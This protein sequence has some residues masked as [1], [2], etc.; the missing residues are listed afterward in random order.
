MISEH[1]SP[2]AALGGVD[3][4]G[5]NVYVA[6]LGAALVRQGHDVTVY[7]RRDNPRIGRRI[8][9]ASGVRVVHIEAG[10]AKPIAKDALYPLMRTF[11]HDMR[12]DVA[13]FA[14][15]VLHAHFWMSGCAALDVA[16]PLGIP[17]V[18]TFHALG[19]EKR[20]HQGRA[21][22]SPDVRLGEEA[23]IARSADRV[24]ATATHEAFAL[25]RMGA[26]PR[27]IR[28]VPCGVDVDAFDRN[29]NVFAYPRRRTHRIVTLS[30]LVERKGVGD[31]IR[32]LARI[33]DC[34]LLVAGGGDAMALGDD[35]EAQRLVRIAQLAGVGDR[36]TLLGRLSRDDVPGLLRS[37]DVVVCSPWYEPFGIVPLEAM[38]C[39]VPVV[40]S[41]VGGLC[42]TV[43]DGTTGLLVPPRTPGAIA[44]AVGALLGDDARRRAYGAAGRRR[45]ELRYTWDRVAAE[46][47]GVY[48]DCAGGERAVD[49]S[50]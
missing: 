31:V 11:A 49:H 43:I 22:T 27:D 23:R 14:P 12:R 30:R 6:E 15:N 2:L 10:P 38:A 45:I 13:G 20:L 48:R 25:R 28:I 19:A 9:T 40:A 33:P 17:V 29:A 39:R 5:Q 32:A 34:E 18:Q 8:R 41:A 46:M 44:A 26:E 37:A 35:D 42:D 21:D 47:A 50:A 1:A 4:G 36:V 3:A 24:V 7:T 16:R